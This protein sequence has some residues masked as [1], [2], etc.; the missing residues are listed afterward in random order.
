MEFGFFQQIQQYDVTVT[1]S[2]VIVSIKLCPDVG[3]N[4]SIVL[5]NFGGR[6]NHKRS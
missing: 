3:N 5:C 1:S 2:Y 6:I 4:E